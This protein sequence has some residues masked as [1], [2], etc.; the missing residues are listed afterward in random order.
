MSVIFRTLKQLEEQSPAEAKERAQKVKRDRKIYSLQRVLLSHRGIPSIVFF[1][2]LTAITLFYGVDYLKDYLEQQKEAPFVA[3]LQENGNIKAEKKKQGDEGV[4]AIIEKEPIVV[5]HSTPITGEEGDSEGSSLKGIQSA[6]YLPPG[7]LTDSQERD[8]HSRRPVK[9]LISLKEAHKPLSDTSDGP[10]FLPKRLES[11]PTASSDI[12]YKDQAKTRAVKPPS[13]TL[14]KKKL[15]G[16]SAP[17]QEKQ[18]SKEPLRPKGTL[19]TV[20]KPIKWTGE[21]KSV[22]ITSLVKKIQRSI[23]TSSSNQVEELIE[24][25][26]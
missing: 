17:A 4:K 7:S 10:I 23:N 19:L 18:G 9:A 22:R 20:D 11:N 16:I 8:K 15:Q 21:E 1:I 5:P 25:L 14:P 12:T 2:L 3:T 6:H 24:Q 13:K 26:P